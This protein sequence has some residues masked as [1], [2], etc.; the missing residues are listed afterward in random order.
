MGR[1]GAAYDRYRRSVRG[2]RG[3]IREET[4]IAA[5]FPSAGIISLP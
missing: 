4:Y 1:D 3:W 5:L 2:R